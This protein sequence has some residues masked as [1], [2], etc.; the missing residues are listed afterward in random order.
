MCRNSCL[1]MI[2]LLNK[3]RESSIFFTIQSDDSNGER[4]VS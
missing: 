2:D 3:V 4:I 1:K